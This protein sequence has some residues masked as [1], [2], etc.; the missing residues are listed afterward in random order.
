LE[1]EFNSKLDLINKGVIF[2]VRINTIIMIQ[3]IQSLYLIFIIILCL[4]LLNGSILNFAD[5]AGTAVKL[6]ATGK[7]HDHENLIAQVVP[8]WSLTILTGAICAISIAALLLF[9][10][11]RLQM[12]LTTALIVFS[13][14][15]T[16]TFSWLILSVIHDF[17]M[18]FMP[19]IK[20]SFPVLILIFALLALLGIRKDE[21]LVKS[22]D[23]LR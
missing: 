18:T 5:G 13:V 4:F 15:L 17:K 21:R 23:R 12:F 3:R 22:Y 2:A 10:K 6:S 7:L 19:G 11:R 9:R 1:W 20:M 14:L 8:A 16:G